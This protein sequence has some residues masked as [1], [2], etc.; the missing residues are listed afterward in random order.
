MRGYLYLHSH[1]P[2]WAE[3]G[4]EWGK[5]VWFKIS[6]CINKALTLAGQQLSDHLG[7]VN[8]H[9]SSEGWTVGSL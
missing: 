6:T 7:G 2:A 8:Q 5:S 1:L 3:T 4:V 9:P